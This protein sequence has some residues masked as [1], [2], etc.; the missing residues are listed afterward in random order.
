MGLRGGWVVGGGN[1]VK[2]T[3]VGGLVVHVDRSAGNGR[4]V[5]CLVGG[6]YERDG[7]RA[8]CRLERLVYSTIMGNRSK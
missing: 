5:C 3:I 8:S 6:G 2:G 4:G 1:R 7:C